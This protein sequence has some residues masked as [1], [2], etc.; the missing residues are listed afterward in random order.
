[1]KTNRE[2]FIVINHGVDTWRTSK[3]HVP[4]CKINISKRSLLARQKLGVTHMWS[5]SLKACN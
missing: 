2:H 5:T 3:K 4:D 1:M